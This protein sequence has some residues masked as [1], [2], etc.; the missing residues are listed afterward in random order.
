[1][2]RQNAPGKL[3]EERYRNDEANIRNENSC[4][5]IGGV[6]RVRARNAHQT[7]HEQREEWKKAQTVAIARIC[8][9]VAKP[10]QSD[11][12]RGVPARPAVERGMIGNETIG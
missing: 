7:T 8:L 2:P 12:V 10:R 9:G 1:M 3:R 5:R 4:D 6:V 11:V